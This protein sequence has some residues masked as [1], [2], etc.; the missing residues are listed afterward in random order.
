MFYIQRCYKVLLAGQTGVWNWITVTQ[1][2][3]PLSD[4]SPCLPVSAFENVFTMRKKPEYLIWLPRC[5]W[6]TPEWVTCRNMSGMNPFRSKF[7]RIPHKENSS[8][9]GCTAVMCETWENVV[10]KVFSTIFLICHGYP[11]CLLLERNLNT[12]HQRDNLRR[13]KGS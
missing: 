7:Y 5:Q 4:K 8:P 13:T 2:L 10:S 6:M 3:F 9:N 12:F 1:D 11:L